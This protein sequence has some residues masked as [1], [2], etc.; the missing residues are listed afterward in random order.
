MI[1]PSI[2]ASLAG[3]GGLHGLPSSAPSPAP[4]GS[5]GGFGE[6]LGKY[7]GEVDSLQKQADTAI[8]GLAT[9]DVKD[10]H[11]VVLALNEADMAF[12]LMLEVRN[13]L[14]EAYQEV[15]KLQI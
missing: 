7:L 4:A 14:V 9:G 13:K 15:S 1:D 2:A 6:V 5:T 12:K 8:G 11:D 3:A 10:V